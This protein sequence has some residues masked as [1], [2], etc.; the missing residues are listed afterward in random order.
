MNVDCIVGAL[1]SVQPLI[2]F[3]TI[4]R[5]YL[6]VDGYFFAFGTF[7]KILLTFSVWCVIFGA[8]LLVHP[9]FLVSY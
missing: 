6:D 4:F 5:F 3:F 9:L 1:T 8:C 2:P 7:P